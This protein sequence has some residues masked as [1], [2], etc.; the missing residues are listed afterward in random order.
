M[1]GAAPTVPQTR[2]DPLAQ[3]GRPSKASETLEARPTP[4]PR[5]RVKRSMAVPIAGGAVVLL[6]LGGGAFALK[7]R[8]GGT[9]SVPDSTA[10]QTAIRD[11]SQKGP[12]DSTR[13]GTGPVVPPPVNGGTQS[14]RDTTNVVKPGP[15][16][17]PNGGQT[18][19]DTA[20]P[21]NGGGKPA[22]DLNAIARQVHGFAM[23]PE[24]TDDLQ[25]RAEGKRLGQQAYDIQSLPD[26]IRAQAAFIVSE[27][28]MAEKSRDEAGNWLEKA[29]RLQEKTSWRQILNGIRN[30]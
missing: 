18:H 5:P 26:T 19:P 20:K 4:K 23:D 14:G 16:V 30:Q 7:G 24:F 1:S 27:V 17:K 11:T 29:L 12:S 8:L 13:N 21:A 6:A 10:Q 15:V 3:V 2:I 9:P 28:L 22:P 25:R